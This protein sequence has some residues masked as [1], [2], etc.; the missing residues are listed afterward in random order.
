MSALIKAAYL[1]FLMC[2]SSLESVF[3]DFIRKKANIVKTN[4]YF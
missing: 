1:L 3:A 2:E 4:L